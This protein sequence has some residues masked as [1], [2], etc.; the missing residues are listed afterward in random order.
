LN[1]RNN[2]KSSNVSR[3]IDRVSDF[4]EDISCEEIDV[5]SIDDESSK[6]KLKINYSSKP[7]L[8]FDYKVSKQLI[9]QNT[10]I[11]ITPKLVCHASQALPTQIN[12]HKPN[13][14]KI[15]LN[16]K[17]LSGHNELT[18][19]NTINYQAN[20]QLPLQ[21]RIH[22]C[23]KCT[24]HLCRNNSINI[25]KTLCTKYYCTMC[26]RNY[27]RLGFSVHWRKIHC[28]ILRHEK[29]KR[30]PCSKCSYAFVYEVALL[31]H[32]EHVHNINVRQE[33]FVD[34]TSE[35]SNQDFK[36]Q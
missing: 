4:D 14:L 7:I 18:N 10:N 30:H 20:N 28:S 11:P 31:M 5:L 13:S 21:N 26:K 35:E 22:I 9:E 23:G 24:N 27:S 17:I 34:I 12:V 19:K 2:G 36:F 16:T 33:T 3:S 8:Y 29:N 25:E 6:Y 1:S 32:Y 15:D